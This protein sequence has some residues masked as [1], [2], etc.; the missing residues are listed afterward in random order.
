MDNRRVGWKCPRCGKSA[1]LLLRTSEGPLIR[2]WRE[3]KSFVVVIVGEGVLGEL[4]QKVL[5]G[6]TVKKA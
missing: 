2:C 6:A 5:S 4:A 1:V 3:Q